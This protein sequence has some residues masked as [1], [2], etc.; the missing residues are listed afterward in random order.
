MAQA[1]SR[2]PP[3][4][5][6]CSCPGHSMS[7][8]GRQSVIGT[9]FSPSSS[10]SPCQ[11]CFSVALHTHISS[12]RWTVVATVQIQC[13]TIDM[14]TASLRLIVALVGERSWLKNMCSVGRFFYLF[15]LYQ[16]EDHVTNQI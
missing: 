1:V 10:V 5:G 14:N 11:C 8:C 7:I 12:G 4:G 13:H 6:L 16:I 2:R 3:R 15:E 9:E